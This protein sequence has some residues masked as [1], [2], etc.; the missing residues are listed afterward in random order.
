MSW[1]VGHESQS[2]PGEIFARALRAEGDVEIIW[3]GR[4]FSMVLEFSNETSLLKF[5]RPVLNDRINIFF[6]I[7]ETSR[8]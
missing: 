7:Y 6:W 3:E 1:G 4:S 8:V 5:C 2:V